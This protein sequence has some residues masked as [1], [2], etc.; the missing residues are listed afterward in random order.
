MALV[1][2]IPQLI[3]RAE[4]EVAKVNEQTARRIAEDA[5]SRAPRD[6]GELAESIE[7]R[8]ADDGWEVATDTWYAHFPEFGT[9]RRGAQP[10]L[11]PAAEAQRKA[12]RD[13]LA[14]V[15]K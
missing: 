2:R 13:A 15:Y 10:F 6:S 14:D 12:H 5:K 3:A 4:R 1:S 9:A 7:A 11:T 8:E